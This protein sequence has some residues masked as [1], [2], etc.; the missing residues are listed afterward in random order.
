MHCSSEASA[1]IPRCFLFSYTN[2]LSEIISVLLHDSKRTIEDTIF[3][4]E[5][6]YMFVCTRMV[7]V[8]GVCWVG[9]RVYEQ[10]LQLYPDERQQKKKNQK[11]NL[12]VCQLYNKNS[13]PTQTCVGCFKLVCS[14]KFPNTNQQS[15]QIRKI[16]Y[17]KMRPVRL[18]YKPYFFDQQTVFFSR[19]KSTIAK[20]RANP[21]SSSPAILCNFF[22]ISPF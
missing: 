16:D 7:C 14:S 11:N 17:V 13:V 2:G 8:V 3:R 4:S 22:A 12:K 15:P 21:S 19:N 10:M 9:V 5:C 6:S 18:T 1:R 20:D